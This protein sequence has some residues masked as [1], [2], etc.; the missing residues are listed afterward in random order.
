MKKTC[1][2]PITAKFAMAHVDD[3]SQAA[4]KLRIGKS[5]IL[6][7]IVVRYLPDYLESAIKADTKSA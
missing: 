6:R 1:I 2:V 4:F 7:E 5:T 3:I